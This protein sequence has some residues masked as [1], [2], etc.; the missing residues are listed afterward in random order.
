MARQCWAELRVVLPRSIALGALAGAGVGALVGTMMV[1]LFGTIAGGVIGAGAGALCGLGSGFA[2]AAVAANAGT[3]EVRAV[4]ALAAG[5]GGLL[6]AMAVY[7]HK[8]LS[9]IGILVAVAF[10][11][12][13]AGLG[14]WMAPWAAFNGTAPTRA[15]L[16]RAVGIC[17]VIGAGA[18]AVIGLGLGLD[19]YPPTALFALVEGALFGLLIGTPIGFWIALAWSVTPVNRKVSR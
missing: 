4:G 18:G 6:E 7:Q 19:A 13:C 1:P 14:A 15:M 5:A 8:A 12:V 10:A 11:V 9:T 16:R 2:L 3:R 17:A